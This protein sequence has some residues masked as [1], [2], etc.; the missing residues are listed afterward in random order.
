MHDLT[1]LMLFNI[2]AMQRCAITVNLICSLCL[3][4][5]AAR[6][7]GE[8]LAVQ[9]QGTSNCQNT[10]WNQQKNI[11]TLQLL[12]I[13][14]VCRLLSLLFV[15]INYLY[16]NLTI[17]FQL[18]FTSHLKYPIDMDIFSIFIFI[19]ACVKLSV[20]IYVY[21]CISFYI[22]MCEDECI[23][24]LC[25]FFLHVLYVFCLPLFSF[26]LSYFYLASIQVQT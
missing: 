21:T 13:G 20:W 12:N 10:S 9:Q 3:R 17:L 5:Q 25:M 24:C 2:F 8:L 7:Q 6:V 4:K 23:N 22:Y 16:R 26:S 11:L 19:F 14:T 18:Y 1:G 15:A